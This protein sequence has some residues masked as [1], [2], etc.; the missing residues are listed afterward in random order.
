M[1]FIPT[2]TPR[3]FYLHLSQDRTK[4]ILQGHPWVFAHSLKELPKAPSGTRALLKDK[5]GKIIAKGIY[6]P[7]SQLAFR[8]CC[9][10]N[11]DLGEALIQDRIERAIALRAGIFK[12]QP[13]NS[14]SNTPLTTAYRLINGEGDRLPGLICD[15]YADSAVFQ[16]DG[17]GP[18]GFWNI[19]DISTW[20]MSKLALRHVILKA[21]SK[22]KQDAQNLSKTSF[23]GIVR[24]HENGLSFEADLLRGQ[25]TGFFLDQRDNRKEIG[26][27]S[28]GKRVLNLFGYT[29]GF[30]VYAAAAGASDV[31]TVDSAKPAMLSAQRNW[32]LNELSLPHHFVVADAFDYLSNAHQQKRRWDIVIIDP[33]SFA[34]SQKLVEKA[35]M[36]YISLL[37]SGVDVTESGGILAASSCSSHITP[38]MFYN[39]VERAISKARARGT[40]LA[41]LGQPKDHPFPL[42]CQEL[43]YLKF[44]LVRIER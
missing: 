29:G 43:R 14:T 27:I 36:N 40:V 17:E 31:T 5:S 34:S 44:M 18:Q 37:S 2:K 26:G 35:E 12:A 9:L 22:S 16:L 8:V 11:E 42:A 24:F 21:R 20:L 6:D 13:T 23:D 38:V 32:E 25:K 7:A 10:E 3:P 39:I 41:V 28:V 1:P 19:E 4:A 33:P 15:I 30:S